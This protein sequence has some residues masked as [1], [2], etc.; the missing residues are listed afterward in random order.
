MSFMGGIGVLR[1][2]TLNQWV[3][4]VMEDE[5]IEVGH[6]NR[7]Y[8]LGDY[9]SERL[10]IFVRDSISVDCQHPLDPNRMLTGR[11]STIGFKVYEL[12]LKDETGESNENPV[13]RFG[14]FQHGG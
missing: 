9:A 3:E 10:F 2:N 7:T 8:L 6:Y 11:R 1:I 4:T 13:E 14:Y 5:V 12:G